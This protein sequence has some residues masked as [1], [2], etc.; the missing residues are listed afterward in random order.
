MSEAI[1][2]M[3][4]SGTGKS[5][6]LMDLD[7]Q[8]TMLIQ[9]VKKRL[10]FKSSHWKKLDKDGLGSVVV[11]DNWAK[12]ISGMKKSSELGKE[13]VV[14]DDFQYLLSNEFM[15]RIGE[16]GYDKFNDLAHHAWSVI[17]EAKKGPDNLRVYFLTHTDTDDLGNTRMKTMG[18]L[19]NEKI[20]LEGLF[21]IV[22]KT[23]VMN[24]SYFFS[25][26]NNGKD[27]VKSPI[28]L[29]EDDKI[30]NNLKLIDDMI[31]D[32]YDI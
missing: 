22:L 29:F 31:C 20:A 1:L 26:K 3:G 5:A 12:I 10:P 11:T 23:M 24:G 16:K 30:E 6:S 7:P 8:K 9:T 14:V 25:T 27:T 28:G 19:L 13:I 21:T 15:N 4:E 18:K 32:Y 2:I 17:N